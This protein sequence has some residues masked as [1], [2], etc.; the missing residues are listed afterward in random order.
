M[1]IEIPPE[2]FKPMSL[3]YDIPGEIKKKI[4]GEFY[5]HL[6]NEI[7]CIFGKDAFQ[8]FDKREEFSLSDFIIGTFGMDCAVKAAC[9]K[10]GLGWLMDY[11]DSLDWYQSDQFDS[12]VIEEARESGGI[13][14]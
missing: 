8:N 7:L 3:K 13:H 5:K 12:E 4:P 2:E 14:R 9:K 10:L 6:H 1:A 11:Y